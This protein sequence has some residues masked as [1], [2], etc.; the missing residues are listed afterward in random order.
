MNSSV[1]HPRA[2]SWRFTSCLCL[3]HY[4]DAASCDDRVCAAAQS[5][6]ASS[7]RAVVRP[8][9]LAIASSHRTSRTSTALAD[10]LADRVFGQCSDSVR[11]SL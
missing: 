2:S 7:Q 11:R 9:S 6:S 1:G 5:T 8:A 3:C 4:V 10:R